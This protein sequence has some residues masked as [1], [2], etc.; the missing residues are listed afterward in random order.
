MRLRTICLLISLA[1]AS[2]VATPPAWAQKPMRDSKCSDCKGNLPNCAC[3]KCS[4][5][6]AKYNRLD[7]CSLCNRAAAEKLAEAKR[8]EAEEQERRRRQQ[9]A[10]EREWAEQ[11]AAA[12]RKQ[13][14]SD[15]AA[16]E[17]QK[18]FNE[19]QKF[20]RDSDAAA[21]ESQKRFNEQQQKFK[22][23]SD[24]AAAESRKRFNEQQQK[25][26]HDSEAQQETWKK[27]REAQDQLWKKLSEELDRPTPSPRNP[28]D[29]DDAGADDDSEPLYSPP[30][31]PFY[32][33]ALG[34]TP[35]PTE[36]PSGPTDQP[37]V[38]SPS[39]TPRPS[40]V[41]V[42]P[43]PKP[44]YVPTPAD[45]AAANSKKFNDVM[46]KGS[47]GGASNSVEELLGGG[48]GYAPDPRI[49]DLSGAGA[50]GRGTNA[51]DGGGKSGGGP[52]QPATPKQNAAENGNNFNDVM[53]GGSTGDS[54]PS[55]ADLLG[56]DAESALS[57]VLTGLDVIN[58]ESPRPAIPGV[59]DLLRGFIPE[60]EDPRLQEARDKAG[61]AATAAQTAA[62]LAETAGAKV[63]KAV[64]GA[65]GAIG[66]IWDAGIYL[67]GKGKEWGDWAGAQLAPWFAKG[68]S[69][70]KPATNN[71]PHSSPEQRTKP[72]GTK[73]NR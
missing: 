72:S 10:F 4:V 22:R 51:R 52:G 62:G 56:V 8:K 36:P 5:H 32:R 28:L 49:K 12:K 48:K 34:P 64:G 71:V 73:D 31:R 6:N 35:R 50:K 19:Q 13:A 15:A 66:L 45:I 60:S 23:D 18:R 27:I 38:W 54:S 55:I 47:R 58:E 41:L 14:E 42:M 1:T 59:K 43:A 63:P 25:N 29:D 9:E 69:T 11:A 46:G 2:I 53:S 24:A 61:S 7:G 37:G 26:K 17:S 70:A 20:K 39:P 68:P 3:P 30:A 65:L 16:A 21:A 44:V 57:D 67:T 40:P 33:P